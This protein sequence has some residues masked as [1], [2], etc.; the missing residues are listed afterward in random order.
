MGGDLKK[1][2]FVL[3]GG[4][5]RFIFSERFVLRIINAINK[6]TPAVENKSSGLIYCEKNSSDSLPVVSCAKRSIVGVIGVPKSVLQQ[7]SI[8][9]MLYVILHNI[10]CNPRRNILGQRL[11]R[12]L[13]TYTSANNSK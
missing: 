6:I 13:T 5:L 10:I 11:N 2:R 1:E 4:T 7:A 12:K 8:K 3:R 9:A